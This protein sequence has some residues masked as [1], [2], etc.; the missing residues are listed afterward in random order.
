M[1]NTK[2]ILDYSSILK[3]SSC[4]LSEN[5]DDR[6]KHVER[7][8][9]SIISDLE[10]NNKITTLTEQNTRS[11][12]T[13][14]SNSKMASKYYDY[15]LSII[16]YYNEYDAR[17][18]NTLVNDFSTSV[19]PYVEN[20]DSLSEALNTRHETLFDTQKTDMNSIVKKFT[21]IDRILENHNTISKR[22]NIEN[23][24]NKL[25][26]KTESK[27]IP[28]KAVL[29]NCCSMIDTYNLPCYQKMNICLEE[30]YYLIKKNKISNIKF[31]DIVKSITEY[32]LMNNDI[33]S[34][35]DMKGI[36]KVLSENVV[37]NEDDTSAV[38][39]VV[40]DDITT[41]SIIKQCIQSFLVSP[42][43]NTELFIKTINLALD[44]DFI[45]LSNNLGELLIFICDGYNSDLYDME[46]L[47]EAL[48]KWT[49]D[50]ETK[51][52]NALESTDDTT[53]LTREYAD[54]I[55]KQI[56]KA[57]NY[58]SYNDISKDSVVGAMIDAIYKQLENI[59]SIVYSESNVKMIEYL[60]NNNL[61][62]TPLNELKIFK[63]HNLIRALS[64][65]DDFLSDKIQSGISKIKSKLST[66]KD[67]VEDVLWP[68][69]K[70]KKENKVVKFVKDAGK[71][72]VDKANSLIKG[73]VSKIKESADDSILYEF[74]GEDN[75]FDVTI[76][77]MELSVDNSSYIS[78]VSEEI[79]ALCRDINVYLEANS[80][81]TLKCYYEINPSFVSIHIKDATPLILSETE[82]QLVKENKF[83]S[84][85]FEFYTNL[86]AESEIYS[87]LSKKYDIETELLNSIKES[88]EDYSYDKF[89]TMLEISSILG[90]NYSI[91]ESYCNKFSQ[92][93]FHKLVLN[94]NEGIYYIDQHKIEYALDT[95]RSYDEATI[96]DKIEALI[97]FE[98]IINGTDDELI[99]DEANIPDPKGKDN[100]E[101]K[102]SGGGGLNLNKMKLYLQGLKTK[103]KG[104]SQKEKEISKKIDT[105]FKS[106]VKGLKDSLVSDRREAIIKGS[107][108][109]SFSKCIK[110]GAAL[111]GIAKFGHPEVAAIA[112][113]GGLIASKKLTKKERLLLLDELDIELDVIEKE[114]N[115]AESR[116]QM[117]KYRA[118]MQQKKSLQRQQQRIKYNI[119]LGKDLMPNSEMGMK[120]TS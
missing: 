61:T 6:S 9:E 49:D 120:K 15:V 80:Y 109:P 114:I 83:K 90:A 5:K 73:I 117:K 60:A 63:R 88:D 47:D 79:D 4:L 58:I 43:K 112:A 33:I 26:I 3:R 107:V 68:E 35:K 12:I 2:I 72:V 91:I 108:I 85:E 25:K 41:G 97:L 103:F 18:A 84:E 69:D 66:A 78:E 115:N 14:M 102:K 17:K 22:F 96:S 94:E 36:R 101:E 13:E 76:Y 29:N 87:E 27:V 119:R 21:A 50:L 59:N 42:E 45:D 8:I 11:L 62:P 37:L 56:Q 32:F 75:K 19:I 10:R 64:N 31:S 106:L 39:F 105:S 99:I 95:Y 51:L 23:E 67:K 93:K 54:S 53:I 44:C 24:I 20:M 70:P 38:S 57:C 98:S 71:K 81:E 86:L 30:V 7:I 74:I 34:A 28:Q 104:M 77:R 89:E 48:V 92:Y 46:E 110:I 82:L 40:K 116:G 113:I 65:L 118:L 1:Y 100:K 52:S 111:A 55:F 16:E